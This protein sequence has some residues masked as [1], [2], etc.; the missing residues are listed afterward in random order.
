[1]QYFGRNPCLINILQTLTARKP[2]NTEDL[3]AGNGGGRG[4]PLGKQIE[5]YKEKEANQD[6]G[7]KKSIASRS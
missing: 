1:M 7:C 5:K 4:Y 3:R 2:L 6:T